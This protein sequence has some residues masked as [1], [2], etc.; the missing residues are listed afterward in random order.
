MGGVNL[1]D[2][3]YC[4]TVQ[5]N[6]A[7][8]VAT[9]IPIWPMCIVMWD[10]GGNSHKMV[11]VVAM[12]RKARWCQC[13]RQMSINGCPGRDGRVQ[14]GIDGTGLALVRDIS[15]PTPIWPLFYTLST[16][17]LAHPLFPNSIMPAHRQPSTARSHAAGG[18]YKASIIVISSD[19]EEEPLPVSK[20]GSRKPR[21]SRVEGEILEILDETPTKS[22]DSELES[23]R[24]RCHELE[25]ACFPHCSI[26]PPYKRNSYRPNLLGAQCVEE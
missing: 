18:P 6:T 4:A 5:H 10:I 19:E 26:N 7:S 13:Q 23:L 2:R 15:T 21:R 17:V 16:P 9:T 24:R 14:P 22:E 11:A 3:A 25:Q 20:R 1:L 12:K 8:H